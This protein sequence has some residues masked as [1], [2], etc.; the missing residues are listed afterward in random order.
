[1]RMHTHRSRIVYIGLRV[2]CEDAVLYKWNAMSVSINWCIII[3]HSTV[4]RLG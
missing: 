1:M 3:I 2:N 4:L